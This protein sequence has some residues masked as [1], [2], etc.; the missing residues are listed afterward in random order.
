MYRRGSSG[1]GD[2][3]LDRPSK[4]KRPS[5]ADMFDKDGKDGEERQVS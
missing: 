4:R 1:R 5:A 2:D 3:D